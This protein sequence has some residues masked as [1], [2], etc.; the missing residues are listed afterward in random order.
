MKKALYTSMVASLGK[1]CEVINRLIAGHKLSDEQ[2]EVYADAANA[3]RDNL[4]HLNR[5]INVEYAFEEG[6]PQDVLNYYQL[7]TQHSQPIEELVAYLLDRQEMFG[8]AYKYETLFL[9]ESLDGAAYHAGI[10]VGLV[11]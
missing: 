7:L 4:I 5:M 3:L 10:I 9:T 11:N 8:D 6:L 2:W 1:S